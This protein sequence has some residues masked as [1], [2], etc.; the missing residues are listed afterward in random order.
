VNR[1][2]TPGPPAVERAAG[3]LGRALDIAARIL[4][5]LTRLA[6]AAAVAASAA[7]AA[8]LVEDA[9]GGTDEW[10]ARVALLGLAL[11]APAVVLLFV[12]GLRDLRE[13]PRRAGSLPADVR[14]AAADLRAR[15]RRVPEPAGAF[16]VLRALWRLGRLV[17][18]SRDVL[19]PYAAVVA[20]L[21]PPVLLAALVAAA[22]AVV[23]VPAAAVAILLI[24]A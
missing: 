4:R 14:A 22:V 17:T 13:L 7:W 3:A 10:M 16:G 2:R 1:R 18:G 20:A 15:S 23:E 9:P 12:A 8:W 21:R 24:L 19:T 11:A 5:G 6:I